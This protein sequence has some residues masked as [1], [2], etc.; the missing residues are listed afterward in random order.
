MGATDVAKG[1]ETGNMR[2]FSWESA[3]WRF[4][5]VSNYANTKFSYISKDVQKAQK[6]I[7]GN[8]LQIQDSIEHKALSIKDKNNRIKY[9]TSYTVKQGNYVMD[10]WEKLAYYIFTKYN[11]CF[12]RDK[13]NR[14]Q[15][16]GYT[17]EWKKRVLKDD[18]NFKL[19]VW[20]NSDKAK[21]P[22]NF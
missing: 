10:R 15:A 5:L 13:N 7:E 22:T 18:A 21:E 6:E 14:P 11:D 8:F 1:F 4:N 9:L 16:K 2:E 20:Q 19:P 3:W 17:N 12:I